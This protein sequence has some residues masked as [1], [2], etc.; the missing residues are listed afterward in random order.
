MAT[1]D[2]K[3][4]AETM[5]EKIMSIDD[6]D[7]KSWS[8]MVLSAYAEGKAAGKQEERQKWEQKQAATA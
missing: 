8:L 2:G 4:M 5:A 3:K 6:L 1:K 7:G